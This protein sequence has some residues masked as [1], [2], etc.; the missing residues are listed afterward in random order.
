MIDMQRNSGYLFLCVL[1]RVYTSIEKGEIISI[2]K[3]C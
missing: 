1:C 2:K 3:V